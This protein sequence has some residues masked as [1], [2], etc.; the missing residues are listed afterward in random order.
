MQINPWLSAPDGVA[1]PPLVDARVN[2]VQA[3]A[4]SPARLSAIV[5]PAI[6]A[7]G[8]ENRLPT[9]PADG[10]VAAP[11]WL[12]VHGGAGESTLEQ[13]LAGS[14]AADHAWPAARDDGPRERV[15]LVARTHAAGLQAAQRAAGEWASGQRPVELL[16]LVLID[17]APGRLPRPL[18]DLA[19]LVAG[20]VPRL[21]RLAWVEAW[22]LGEPVELQSAPRSVRGVIADLRD[23]VKAPSLHHP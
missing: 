9:R 11:W 5:Q 18:R 3:P 6:P 21:W 7:P 19:E 12:G 22:R 14:R 15:V 8:A 2:P 16:G 4:P 20:G 17:D 1:E 10:R 13:L 23:L